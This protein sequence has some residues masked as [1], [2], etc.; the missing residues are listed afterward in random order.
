VNSSL[1]ILEC[2]KNPLPFKLI[3]DVR[4]I[5][6]TNFNNN[7]KCLEYFKELYMSLKFKK[8]FRD[9]LWIRVRLPKIEN[10]YHPDNLKIALDASNDEDFNETLNYW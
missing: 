7:I 4:L 9:W 8:Q 10:K 1:K 5:Q 6:K 3:H 2:E